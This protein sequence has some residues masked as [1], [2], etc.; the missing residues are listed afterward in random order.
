MK[1]ILVVVSGLLVAVM[2]FVSCSGE[3][4]ERLADVDS[5]VCDAPDSA[6]AVLDSIPLSCLRTREQRA[7]YAL[8]KS[9]A[10]DK[11]CIDV[12]SDSIIAPAVKYY[13]RHGSP[14]EKLRTYYYRGLVSYYSDDLDTAMEYFS[15]AAQYAPKARDKSVAGLLYDKMA[16]VYTALFDFDLSLNKTQ[17]AATAY[18]EA[19]DSSYYADE[20]MRMLNTEIVLGRYDSASMLVENIWKNK[21]RIDSVQLSSLYSNTLKIA[22]YTK[23]PHIDS[24]IS[25]YR[26]TFIRNENLVDW[27]T[28]A[29][30]YCNS[31]D[32]DKAEKT[33]VNWGLILQVW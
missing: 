10:L 13:R 4:S 32:Y 15:K 1:K 26:S 22:T 23:N 11:S 2:S 24:I 19:G 28:V 31:N 12:K 27:L 21:D 30:A 7:K 5:L 3:V 25:G 8:L 33:A 9:V 16:I 6:L 14:D 20:L 17:M 29:N 18:L